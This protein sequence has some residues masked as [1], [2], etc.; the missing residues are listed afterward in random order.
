[1]TGNFSAWYVQGFINHAI[2]ILSRLSEVFWAIWR[3]D[4]IFYQMFIYRLTQMNGI[5]NNIS[6][7]KR[8]ISQIW[9]YIGQK[10]KQNPRIERQYNFRD[11]ILG[12]TCFE[13]CFFNKFLHQHRKP[14]KWCYIAIQHTQNISTLFWGHQ[15]N[16]SCYF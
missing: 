3:M 13:N 15:W 2:L 12:E 9:L 1:M 14:C 11:T 7:N 16:T 4:M 5:W 6:G 10:D 8:A